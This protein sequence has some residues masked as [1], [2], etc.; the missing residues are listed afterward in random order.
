MRM[1]FT[2]RLS[3]TQI[4]QTWW[5]RQSKN[6]VSQVKDANGNSIGDPL[7]T[8]VPATAKSNHD[9]LVDGLQSRSAPPRPT[10]RGVRI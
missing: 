10:I 4:V 3:D 9:T 6:Y 7:F 2:T 1:N 5:N 8:S